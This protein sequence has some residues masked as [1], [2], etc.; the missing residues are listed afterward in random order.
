MLIV[1]RLV[2]E[3]AAS[4]NSTLDFLERKMNGPKSFLVLI[5]K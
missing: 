1:H 4:K 2:A 3:V 5:A